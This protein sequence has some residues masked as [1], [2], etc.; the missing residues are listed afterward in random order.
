MYLVKNFHIKK[1]LTPWLGGLLATGLIAGAGYTAYSQFAVQQRSET[2]RK[3]KTVAVE[4]LNLPI[5]ISA[6]GTIV[7]ERSVNVSPKTSGMLK[8]LLVNEGDSVEKGQILAYMD[9]SNLQGQLTQ[10]RGQLA[11]A[12]ANLQKLLNGNRSQDI[13]SAKAVLSE[14]QASLE[15]LLNGNR[16]QDVAV[17][18]AQVAEQQANLQKLLNGN[19]TQ[20]IVVA[21]AQLAEQQANLQKLLEGNRPED[22]AQA[23][24]KLKDAEYAENQA[25]EEFQRNQELYN[26]G[27]IA[28]QVVNNSRTARD[29]AGTQVKQAEQ[30]VALL[31]A[32]AR[33]QEIAAARAAVEQKRQ[34]LALARSG[35]RPEDIA[36]GR[37]AVEQ[38]R[39]ALALVRS[40]AR[41]EEIAQ[42][43]AAVE[44]KQQALALLEAGSRPEEIDQA[45]AQVLSAKGSLQSVQALIDDTVLRA[46]FS[47][48][49]TRKYADPGAFVTPTTAGSAVS[50]ATSSSILSLASKNQLIANV[51]ETNIAQ[52]QIGQAASIQADAFAGKTFAG[53]ITQ[54]SPQSIV[55]QNVTSFEVRAAIIDDK[56]MLRSGMNVNVEFKAGELKNVLVVPTAAIVRQQRA[57]GVFVPGGKDGKPAFMPIK[58]GMTV[59]DKTEVRSGLKGDEKVLI[60]VPAGLRPKSQN[61]SSGGIPGLQPGG[62][63]RLR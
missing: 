7:P 5:T 22:I 51:A 37:A 61:P 46:P 16:T 17:A 33:P 28:L 31:K 62:R 1:E 48:T 19:R 6:N 55:Q 32:G 52:I 10:T 36:A 13:A 23:T 38:K 53:K 14:Q 34:A 49:V 27:A 2:G 45:R 58:T 3:E 24:A 44:Q 40:G 59:D 35:A 63:T 56:Q 21:E 26:A 41:P 54:I 15:K 57:T 39:Q 11:A 43:R 20:E 8:S 9:D 29:R 4:R 30:A 42:A 25:E 18:E 50:S 47:G 60:S 12:E